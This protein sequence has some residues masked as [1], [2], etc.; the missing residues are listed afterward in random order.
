LLYQQQLSR[1]QRH[2]FRP[3][4]RS[5]GGRSRTCGLVVQ[6]HAFLPTETTPHRHE[7]ALRE[8]NPP[9]QLGRLVPAPIGQGHVLSRRKERESNPQGCHARPASNGVPSPVGLPFRFTKAAVAG[10]E[11]ASGRLTAAYPYQHGSHRIV[12]FSQDGWIRTTGTDRHGCRIGRSCS[13]GTRNTR[14]SHVLKPIC[15][16]P[17]GREERTCAMAR[18]QAAA[19]SWAL[20]WKPNCQGSIN[21]QPQQRFGCWTSGTGGHRTHIVRFKRPVHCPV[22]HSPEA[23]GAEGVE[24]TAWSL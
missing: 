17:S 6:S 2:A 8:S 16:A 4:V 1:I 18:R 13:R 24:P 22:C 14:L 10:I 3:T 19:T 11:P 7:S 20:G 15:R 23:I 9:V 12:S 21:T 5:C